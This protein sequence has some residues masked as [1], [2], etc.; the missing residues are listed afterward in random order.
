MGNFKYYVIRKE[1]NEIINI[2]DTLDEAQTFTK[3]MNGLG[4][5][6]LSWIGSESGK[7]NRKFF[8]YCIIKLKKDMN[9]E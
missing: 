6:N 5:G 3:K 8:A 7:V 2:F 4:S 9:H 1:D